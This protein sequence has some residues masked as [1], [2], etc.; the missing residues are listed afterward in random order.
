MQNKT[1]FW[2]IGVSLADAMQ[3]HIKRLWIWQQSVNYVTEIKPRFETVDFHKGII[4]INTC[5]LQLSATEQKV[6]HKKSKD[7]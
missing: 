6:E 4:I 1:V 7:P 2:V 3:P 5:L